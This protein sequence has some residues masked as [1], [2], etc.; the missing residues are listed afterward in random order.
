MRNLSI[1]SKLSAATVKKLSS[2]DHYKDGRFRN[3]TPHHARSFA[4]IM[5]KQIKRMIIEKPIDKKPNNVLPINTLSREK[6]ENLSDTQLYI[7]KLGHSYI[8]LKVYGEYLL[9]DPVFSLRASPF[10]FVGPKRFQAPPISIEELPTIDKVI[11]S[12]NHY[13]H[14]DKASIKQLITKTRQFLVPL[15]IDA[16]L[17]TWGVDKAKIKAFDWWQ[18]HQTDKALLAFTPSRHYSGRGF[19]DRNLTLWGSWVIKTTNEN[20][21]FS[22]DSGYFEGFKEIGDKYGPFDLTMIETGAYNKDWP[23][24]HMFPE[25]SVQAHLDLQGKVMMPIHN[26]TFDLSIHPW[27]EPL[28]RVTV[29]AE[30]LH[31]SLMTPTIGQIVTITE[32]AQCNNPWWLACK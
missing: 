27:Y 25:E 9:I 12:H 31:V 7:V 15:G 8:L 6:L 5:L 21:Y 17:Q 28:E 14:L 32:N 22:G 20:L 19:K 29:I 23:G 16:D 11:I 10:T 2:V 30:Q 1:K 18:E 4:R 13:D 24:V 3:S 26:S